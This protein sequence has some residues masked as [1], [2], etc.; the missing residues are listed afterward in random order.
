MSAKDNVALRVPD[1]VGLKVTPTLHVAPEPTVPQVFELTMKSFALAPES[2]AEVTVKFADPV[3]VT[4]TLWA[5]ELAP[6]VV[7]GKVRDVGENEMP[8]VAGGGVVPPPVPVPEPKVP[9]PPR[10]RRCVWSPTPNG[11]GVPL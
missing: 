11:L 5:A 3:F 9:P 10:A 8:G 6:T 7:A 2:V 1:A 4:V